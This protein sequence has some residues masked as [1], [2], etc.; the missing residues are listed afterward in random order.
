MLGEYSIR[1]TPEILLQNIIS[2]L[3]SLKGVPGDPNTSSL[4]KFTDDDYKNFLPK[5]HQ[6][7][8]SSLLVIN[9]TNSMTTIPSLSEEMKLYFHEC[10]LLEEEE[11]VTL[12]DL[13]Q[14]QKIDLIFLAK[15][16][17]ELLQIPFDF[18]SKQVF[19]LNFFNIFIILV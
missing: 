11:E 18:L 6:F 3:L 15:A 2:Q 14:N 12:Q 19:F 9:T 16:F 10:N 17:C 1:N 8:T 13:G 7:V 4:M 5:T